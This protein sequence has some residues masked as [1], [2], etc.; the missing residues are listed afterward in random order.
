MD[1]VVFLPF[2]WF[3]LVLN[4]VCSIRVSLRDLL[5]HPLSQQGF[6]E[7]VYPPQL[8][9]VTH[10]G[11]AEGLIPFQLAALILSHLSKRQLFSSPIERGWPT[12][13]GLEAGKSIFSC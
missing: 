4:L 7:T 13:K 8:V 6:S 11:I 12:L 3:L 10:L 1:K 2:H 5:Q 9:D